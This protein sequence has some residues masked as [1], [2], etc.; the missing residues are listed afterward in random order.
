MNNRIRF[1]ELLFVACAVCFT[2]LSPA[3]LAGDDF[4]TELLAIEHAWDHANY[5]TP[6][7]DA[8]TRAFETLNE[9]TESF[10]RA[11]PGRAEPLVWEGIVR[12]S[13]AGAKGG[14]GALSLAKAARESLLAAVKLDGN[15]LHGSAY[16]SLGVLYYKVPGFP[17]GFG[18]HDKAADYLRKA[19]SLNPDGIDP[20]YFYGEFLF[21]EKEYAE[22]LRYLQKA[23]AAPPRPDRPLAD[24]GRRGEI[25]ALIT[26]VRAKLS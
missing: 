14:L 8:K 10:V 5:E 7:G 15:A 19:L 22:S 23:L 1:A 11:W 3:A 9:R 26:K 4:A 13:Y 20:N 25:D 17:L 2:M 21:E 12:S 16:T 18:S 6:N 24:S